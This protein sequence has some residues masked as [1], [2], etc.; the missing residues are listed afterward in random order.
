MSSATSSSCLVT[1]F[2][3]R[4]DESRYKSGRVAD[5]KS[6]HFAFVNASSTLI[7]LLSSDWASCLEIL[8]STPARAKEQCTSKALAWENTSPLGAGET[9]FGLA[10]KCIQAVRTF[11][12]TG[13][14]ECEDDP[15][16]E[17][18]DLLSKELA[19]VRNRWEALD[20]AFSRI[21]KNY[22]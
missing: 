8:Q 17:L 11:K 3:D 5:P 15:G 14:H 4:G 13:L 12:E 21:E 20:G 2:Y 9:T 16:V 22:R 1:V 18:K 7:Q 19:Y 6:L 10:E